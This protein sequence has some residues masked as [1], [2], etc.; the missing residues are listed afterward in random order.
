MKIRL[1][2]GMIAGIFMMAAV[3]A[4]AQSEAEFVKALAGQWQVYDSLYA[5]DGQDCAI[6]LKEEQTDGVYALE[7]KS[8]NLELSGVSGWRI[9]DGQ[10]VLLAGADPVATLGGNQ[11]RMSGNSN[12]GAPVIL[13]RV[14]EN[15]LIDQMAAARQ[16]SGCYY[17]GFTNTCVDDVQLQKP[18]VPSDGSSAH[19]SVLVNLNARVEARDDA[20]VLGVVPAKSCI[21]VDICSQAADGVWCRAQF[22][23]QVGWLKKQALRQE[24]WPV[25]T[26]VNQCE[27]NA[28][29]AP[30]A[31]AA[32]AA[33]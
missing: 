12:I 4:M 10:L 26:F 25:V 6:T 17:L 14:G 33:Q 5:L 24:K 20:E 23:E 22:G 1:L 27:A 31:P 9:M 3:P 2:A 13:D 19:I 32:P 30:A 8:C 7:A 21:S 18:V 15:G 16:A 28:A 29:V 11:T